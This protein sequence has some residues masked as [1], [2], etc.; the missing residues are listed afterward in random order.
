M[1]AGPTLDFAS[2]SIKRAVKNRPDRLYDKNYSL[3]AET[4][5]REHLFG[6]IPSGVPA[7]SKTPRIPK[8]SGGPG[9]SLSSMMR[10][11]G[12]L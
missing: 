9:V 8:P 10:K 5:R 3:I 4:P 11:G 7:K 2:R 6:L 12:F 1:P